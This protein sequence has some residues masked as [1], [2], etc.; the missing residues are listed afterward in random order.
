MIWQSMQTS[1][2]SRRQIDECP[3]KSHFYYAKGHDANAAILSL[4]SRRIY[5]SI[6]RYFDRFNMTKLF[7]NYS[8]YRI[9]TFQL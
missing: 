3:F 1:E 2:I 5:I 8:K 7:E 6:C 9:I 4:F